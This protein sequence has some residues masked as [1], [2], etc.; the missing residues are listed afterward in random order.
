[1]VCTPSLKSWVN[2]VLFNLFLDLSLCVDL[3]LFTYNTATQ[4]W[5][6]NSKWGKEEFSKPLKHWFG[7]ILIGPSVGAVATLGQVPRDLVP[8]RCAFPEVLMGLEWDGIREGTMPGAGCR[9]L[10][11]AVCTGCLFRCLLR[12]WVCSSIKEAVKCVGV[13]G[14]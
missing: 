13:G 9:A 11:H 1:M 8:A 14:S 12:W 4:R 5:I 10:G 2:L 6:L 7:H 3:S